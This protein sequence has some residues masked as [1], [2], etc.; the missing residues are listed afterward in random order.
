MAEVVLLFV[1][2]NSSKENAKKNDKFETINN[3]QCIIF[4]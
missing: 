4:V 1:V 3:V 2:Y